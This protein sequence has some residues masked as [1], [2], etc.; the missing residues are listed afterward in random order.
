LTSVRLDLETTVVDANVFYSQYQRNVFMT[1]AVERL[2][3]LH[4]TDEIEAEWLNALER[5]RP[6]LGAERLQ[7][8]AQAMKNA[9]PEARLSDYRQYESF[10]VVTDPK[11]RHVAAA[12]I[13]C[14][15][16]A[17][18]TWN[19]RHFNSG[20]LATHGVS[21]SDPDSFLCRIF[22]AGPDVAFAATARSYSFLSKRPGAPVWSEYVDILGRDGLK[23]FAEYLRN[24][25]PTTEVESDTDVWD[26]PKPNEG[27]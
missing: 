19:L 21:V 6:D 27:S 18:V 14:A 23:I 8:T 26:A 17:L 20:E 24:Q 13:K 16:C 11:D 25:A 4:W 10:L 1:F 12:A 7:R 2:F 5:N 22:A 15:P 3:N 9:L